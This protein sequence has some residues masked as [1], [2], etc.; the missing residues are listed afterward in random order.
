MSN[1]KANS[2]RLSLLKIVKDNPP[3]WM[4]LSIVMVSLF[5]YL[6]SVRFGMLWLDDND[7]LNNAKSIKSALLPSAFRYDAV[8]SKT[9]EFYRPVQTLLLLLMERWGDGQL[10]PFHLHC[11]FVH[12]TRDHFSTFNNR[13]FIKQSMGDVTG[14]IKDYDQALGIQPDFTLALNNR[15]LAYLQLGHQ[16]QACRDWQ[17]S[18]GR[19][20]NTAPTLIKK[21][22]KSAEK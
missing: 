2:V 14:A 7:I 15:G 8:L 20:D 13:G 11:I 3:L 16:D 5:L 4:C 21:Y 6:P 1:L 12:L 17:T 10:R 19:G 9:E 22:C 18:A